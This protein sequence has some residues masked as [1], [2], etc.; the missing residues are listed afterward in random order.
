MGGN[1]GKE[2]KRDGVLQEEAKNEEEHE[3]L[4]GQVKDIENVMELPEEVGVKLSKIICSLV[5]HSDSLSDWGSD[6][7]KLA[8]KLSIEHPFIFD[9]VTSK[10]NLLNKSVD[11]L[12][13]YLK[14]ALKSGR[15]GERFGSGIHA[16]WKF[17]DSR[18]PDSQRKEVLYRLQMAGFDSSLICESI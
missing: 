14:V 15:L 6:V 5:F 16:L 1:E 11:I 9:Y 2:L 4:A 17:L 13:W 8:V 7:V 3:K 12:L 10:M 18:I